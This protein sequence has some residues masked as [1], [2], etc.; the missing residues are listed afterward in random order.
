MA[1][2]AVIV[3][4]VALGLALGCVGLFAV[5]QG[6]YTTLNV[7]VPAWNLAIWAILCASTGFAL[8][9]GAWKLLSSTLTMRPQSI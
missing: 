7:D 3:I 5:G 9:L 2:T 4:R 6:L 8:M 1:E